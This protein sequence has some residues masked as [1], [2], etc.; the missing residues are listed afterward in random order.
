MNVLFHL[1]HLIIIKGVKVS[2]LEAYIGEFKRN[3]QTKLRK[4]ESIKKNMRA[5][6]YTNDIYALHVTR[7]K[8][9]LKNIKS[10]L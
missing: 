1:L 8:A 2:F 7:S 10:D 3:G 5:R 9:L 4:I 6:R